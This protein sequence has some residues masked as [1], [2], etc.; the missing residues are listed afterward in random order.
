MWSVISCDR[1]RLTVEAISFTS[2]NV[3]MPIFE[4]IFDF[5]RKMRKRWNNWSG[6]V[7]MDRLIKKEL[8]EK[9]YPI[10]RTQ[11]ENIQL[12]AIQPPGW[13]QIYLFDIIVRPEEEGL[14]QSNR[15]Y[16]II[17][18]DSRKGHKVMIFNNINH[19]TGKFSE[20]SKGLIVR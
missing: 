6:D 14:D 13:L 5:F 2:R 9:G 1:Q 10:S 3:L 16:G 7:E 15:S 20:W 11:L 8:V 18:V 17:K 19:R 4:P 12:R